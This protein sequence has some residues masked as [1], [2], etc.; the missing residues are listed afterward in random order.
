M[1]DYFSCLLWNFIFFLR[2]SIINHVKNI[3]L[4]HAHFFRSIFLFTLSLLS[5]LLSS[6]SPRLFNLRSTFSWIYWINLFVLFISEFNQTLLILFVI[7]AHSNDIIILF[8]WLLNNY[9]LWNF[10][11][12]S[13]FVLL[14]FYLFLNL[15]VFNYAIRIG[16]FVSVEFIN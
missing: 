5:A 8:L 7:H 12:N 4:A 3:V 2:N 15:F 16:Y 6:L 10:K 13:S 9:L 14:Y 1:F 11:I